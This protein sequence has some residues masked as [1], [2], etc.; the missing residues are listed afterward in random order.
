VGVVAP[1][2]PLMVVNKR[3]QQQVPGVLAHPWNL[4]HAAEAAVGNGVTRCEAVLLGDIGPEVLVTDLGEGAV[5]AQ[6]RQG[7][8]DGIHQFGVA[9]VERERA[10]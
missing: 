5:G 3:L 10:Q 7:L 1:M 9:L 8:V 2:G 6:R 4:L